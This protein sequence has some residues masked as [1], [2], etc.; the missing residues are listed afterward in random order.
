MKWIIAVFIAG[1]IT[2]QAAN[3]YYVATNGLDTRTGLNYWTNAV[4][5]ISN[6]VKYATTA[7]DTILVSNG[8]YVVTTNIYITSNITVRSW[9]N[10]N[11]DRTNTIID[12]NY[13][14]I[15]SRCLY[16][17]NT[18][19]VFAGFSLTN[20]CA[21]SATVGAAEANGG[22]VYLKNGTI[23]NCIVALNRSYGDSTGPSGTGG[24]G[25]AVPSSS[26]TKAWIY[27]CDIYG[28]HY[29]PV[30]KQATCI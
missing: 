8:T 3:T 14:N 23:S 12:G 4:L 6:A 29:C 25:I 16:M 20:G 1:A 11:L 17:D 5:T 24:G 13:P 21:A 26:T 30:K 9:N 7:G 2:C 10:G 27:D 15:I 28:N 19:A 18:N 22:G